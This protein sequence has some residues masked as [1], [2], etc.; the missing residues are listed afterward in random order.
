MVWNGTGPVIRMTTTGTHSA[1]GIECCF[2]K[3]C[4]CIHLE[5]LKTFPGILKLSEM[6]IGGLIQ[7]LLMK[8]GLPYNATI[9][10]AFEGALTTSFAC[11]L[12]S[13]ILLACYVL[14]EKSYKMIRSSLFEIM[15]N[16]SASF[17]YLTSAGY[18]FA[19]TKLYL[20]PQYYIIPG[21]DVYP[22]MISAYIMSASVG[23]LHGVDAYF[24]YRQYKTGR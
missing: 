15:F 8:Y 7:S 24:S 9:G 5:F 6:I 19:C 12:T 16:V 17:L 2:C 1:G 11:F 18:L 3:C 4:T 10:P 13:T 20:L 21:F 23:V 22:A 14:S